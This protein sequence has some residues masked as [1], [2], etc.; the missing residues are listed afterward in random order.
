MKKMTFVLCLVML[1]GAGLTGCA[2]NIRR[3][4]AA[5]Q[6]AKAKFGTFSQVEV[7]PVA[8]APTYAGHEAN[9]RAKAKI[10]ENLMAGL[11]MAFPNLKTADAAAPTTGRPGVLRIEP[12]I[13]EIKFIGGMARF[14]A[15]AMAG[16]SA[17][18]MQ[19]N[20][21]D[22]GSGAVIANPEF[23]AQANSWAG[24]WTMGAMDNLMLTRVANECVTYTTANR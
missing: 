8:I 7:A 21:I 18:L 10:E 1:L 20:Y 11:R 9:Q 5:P 16:S 3:P 4:A 12:V 19:A 15:G 17:V 23:Y 22:C 6:P 13:Q 2:T 14:W 24:G